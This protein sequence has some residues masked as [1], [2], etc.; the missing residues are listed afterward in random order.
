MNTP[1]RGG[2]GLIAIYFS[3]AYSTV[4]LFYPYQKFI[5]ISDHKGTCRSE[6]KRA[7]TLSDY[8]WNYCFSRNFGFAAAGEDLY[9]SAIKIKQVCII[10]LFQ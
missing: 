8:F 1:N 7:A 10:E 2:G 5:N 9:K 6:R 4:K 3:P